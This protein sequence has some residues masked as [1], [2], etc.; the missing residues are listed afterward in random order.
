MLHATQPD[1]AL[2]LARFARRRLVLVAV[3]AAGAGL[4]ILMAAAALARPDGLLH[5]WFLDMGQS[6]AVL[7]TTPSGA[8]LL[9]DGGRFPSR[10]LGALGDRL[11][12]NQTQID[13]LA[14]TQPDENEYAAVT[15]VLE[16]YST[17][18]VLTTGQPNQSEAFQ[19]MTDALA[20]RQ[21]VTVKAGYA[22]DFGDGV[23]LDVLSPARQPDLGDSLD[24]HALT[25]RLSCGDISFLLTSDLSA[26]GQRALLK[27][28]Q[29]PPATVMQLPAHG[30]AR[31]LDR[32][33]LA[34]VQPSVIVLQN[35]PANRRGEPDPDTLAELGDLPLYRTDDGGTVHF[36]TDGRELW[37]AQE[38]KVA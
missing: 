11:P 18:L 9:V 30:S 32:D 25:L 3:V 31:S 28:G 36:W 33:F 38:N 13:V 16:R 8:H 29:W 15:S 14:L 12:F 20:S 26:D 27:A 35:D 37:V 24:D 34:A 23:R 5:V 7:V 21:V 4:A 10:L 2:A 22:L 19:A 1:W 17:G 6:N